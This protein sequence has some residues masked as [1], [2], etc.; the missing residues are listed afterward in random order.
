MDSYSQQAAGQLQRFV[1]FFL[2]AAISV[3]FDF[4]PISQECN[5]E[6][7]EKHGRIHGIFP[8]SMGSLVLG[9]NHGLYPYINDYTIDGLIVNPVYSC[10][11]I[12]VCCDKNE[13]SCFL[14]EG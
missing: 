1:T 13:S 2:H 5:K 3:A 11:F 4:C 12:E 14:I 9:K 6:E 7:I 10:R 8:R